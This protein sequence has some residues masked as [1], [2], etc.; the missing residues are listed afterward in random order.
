M[1]PGSSSLQKQAI[2]LRFL[3]ELS[4]K[5]QSLIHS[6]S[7]FQEIVHLIQGKFQYYSIN[8]WLVDDKA[9]AH[10][11]AQAGAQGSLIDHDQRLQAGEG[12][13]GWVVQS[14]RSY[15]C[16]DVRLDPNYTHFA[17][18]I[19][20]RSELTVPVIR[21]G[22]VVA[23]LNIESDQAN[24]FDEG[25]VITLEAVGAQISVAIQNQR[26]FQQARTFNRTLQTAVDEKTN[27][28]RQAQER[29]LEQQRLLQKENR[30]L[31]SLVQEGG[32]NYEIIGRSPAIL[33]ILQMVDRIAPTTATVL[34]QGESGTGK[35]LIARRLHAR[36][37][38]AGQPYVTVNCGALQESLLE[39]ELFGHE[40]GSFT[41]AVNQKMGLCETAHNGTLFLDEIGEMSLAIQAKLLRFLQEG[42]FY[43]IGGKRPIQVDVRIISATNRDLEQEVRA[44]RFREDLYYRLNTIT[45]RMPPLR[46]R[47]EDLPLL[48]DYVLKNPR[49]GGGAKTPT[50]VEPAVFEILAQYAW[51]GNI[52][53]LQNTIER[54]KI[55]SDHSEL[56]L[57][58]IPASI[59]QSIAATP[60]TPAD[61]G[62]KR[63]TPPVI[64][65][66]LG[67]SGG[68]G[69]FP[70]DMPL[71]EV[72]RRHIL[73]ALEH[74]EGNKTK[75]AHSLGIT[76]KT[77]YNKLQR[78]GLHAPIAGAGPDLSTTPP[79]AEAG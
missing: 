48:I 37:E 51:P 31:K 68:A 17:A 39:S 38:R 8:I 46:K 57:E 75:T 29:I 60:S 64:T 47:H 58:H 40:K 69:E 59:R 25:D 73:K 4:M 36:S 42:E 56:R 45:L 21:E 55:L 26:L 15:L 22:Q 77:L 9:V 12:I 10:L 65:P 13:V 28:L 19:A 50:R 11:E 3:N 44:G 66:E 24:A 30:A 53:E 2:Q 5:L 72:E 6:E 33:S 43:R 49:F 76:I 54:M 79:P 7:F 74:L 1:T 14:Q 32:R 23:V 63:Q 71:E 34:I 18:T 41:G 27:E 62:A 61:S 16:P 78:Y 67:S 52:R 35:E 70:P 20:T